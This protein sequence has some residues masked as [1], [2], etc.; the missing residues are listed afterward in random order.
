MHCLKHFNSQIEQGKL[1]TSVL[2]SPVPK[3]F[4][5]LRAVPKKI[6]GW[7]RQ[8]IQMDI[9]VCA[10]FEHFNAS[11]WAKVE[12]GGE[13]FAAEVREVRHHWSTLDECCEWHSCATQE[14]LEACDRI[15]H[16]VRAARES[17]VIIQF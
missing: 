13:H 5:S 3:I 15:P 14:Q 7:W 1:Q 4:S 8:S 9:E 11:L 6:R 17:P 2:Q 16:S 10:L 12:A